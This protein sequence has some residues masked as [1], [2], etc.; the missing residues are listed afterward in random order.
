MKVMNNNP[1]PVNIADDSKQQI[2]LQESIEEW[3]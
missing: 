2:N 1:Q 3:Q